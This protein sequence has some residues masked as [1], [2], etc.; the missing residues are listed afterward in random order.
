MS[1]GGVGVCL[2]VL[3]IDVLLPVEIST[4]AIGK[5]LMSRDGRPLPCTGIILLSLPSSTFMDK[6]VD[7]RSNLFGLR[8]ASMGRVIGVSSVK[9]GAI[10]GPAA[11]TGVNVIRL[12]SSTQVLKRIMMGTGLPIAHVGG[13]TLRAGIRNAILSGTKATRSMLTRVPNLRG[14]TSKFRILNGNSPL[15]CVGNEGLHSVTRLSR[16]ASR[17]VGDMRIIHGP[18]THCSTAMK[19]IIHV[20]AIGQRKSKFKIDLQDSC[21]RSRGSSFMRRTSMGCQRG[22]LSIFTVIHFSG[23]ASLRGSVLRRATFASAV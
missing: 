2:I 18:N 8:T 13:S 16:L 19:T 15:V 21:S 4:R 23:A 14:G 11:P 12:M 17:R 20:H 5:G 1:V 7:N 3:I 22:N 6:A 10:C 9:C